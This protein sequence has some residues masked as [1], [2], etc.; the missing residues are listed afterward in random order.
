MEE[1]TDK[2]LLPTKGAY[3]CGLSKKLSRTMTE[4]ANDQSQQILIT[5]KSGIRN[6]VHRATWLVEMTRR[7][8]L[9]EDLLS[10][11]ERSLPRTANC[12]AACG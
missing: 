7:P 12:G 10:G 2:D 8:V 5:Y 4:E 3:T 1:V 6:A 11:G 9:S